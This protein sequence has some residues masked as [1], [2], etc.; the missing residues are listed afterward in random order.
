MDTSLLLS[1]CFFACL[2]LL[3]IWG[4]KT[5]NNCIVYVSSFWTTAAFF[6]IFYY[7]NPYEQWDIKLS[8]MP[9][10]FM[11]A[12]IWVALVP[13]RKY[14]EKNVKTQIIVGNK[15]FYTIVLYLLVG[16][17][18]EPFIE[19]IVQIITHG[20][21]NIVELRYSIADGKTTARG[22][23]TVVGK[24][25]FS[26]EE[27][28]CFLAI[29]F[30]FLYLLST[31]RPN[32]IMLIGLVCAILNPI[33]HGF[34]VGTRFLPIIYATSFGFNYILLKDRLLDE[35]KHNVKKYS[36]YIVF[37]MIFFFGIISIGRFGKD[38]NYDQEYGTTYQYLRYLGESTVRF[39]TDAFATEFHTDGIR[40]FGG[41]LHYLGLYDRDLDFL[42]W[43]LG[44]IAND[45]YTIIGDVYIDYGWAISLSA[46]C[47]ISLFLY[48]YYDKQSEYLKAGNYI[49]YGMYANIW[50]F[51]IFYNVYTNNFIHAVWTLIYIIIWNLN[52]DETNKLSIR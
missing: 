3:T 40:T 37:F 43:K 39:N 46:F 35:Y 52:T 34:A 4:I 22:Y 25:M 45:F 38:S 48:C 18:F 50:T 2:S 21:S 42:N 31:D 11:L 47:L 51:G 36:K 12:C 20:I 32:K 24:Y 7:L 5:K 41:M 1:I 15:T 29:P 30:F 19:T 26:V 13:F 23:F 10:V 17:S 16:C 8:I 28:L 6:G 33:F 49:L 44:F 9:Y 14:N 27:Y